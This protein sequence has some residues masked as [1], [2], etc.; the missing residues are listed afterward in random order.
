MKTYQE[1][2]PINFYNATSKEA[3]FKFRIPKNSKADLYYVSNIFSNEET[4]QQMKDAMALAKGKTI[5][6]LFGVIGEKESL[7]SIQ[8]DLRRK[9]NELFYYDK[10]EGN[11]FCLVE[12]I[13]LIPRHIL[14]LS[15][16][17]IKE[18]AMMANSIQP[19]CEDIFLNFVS[20][21]FYPELR[22]TGASFQSSINVESDEYT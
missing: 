21:H 12:D 13:R 7:T 20:A 19:H 16:S 3:E 9:E 15:Q 1:S 17:N 14:E 6:G 10:L 4:C 2:V 18:V 5:S 22:P 8:V 11:H